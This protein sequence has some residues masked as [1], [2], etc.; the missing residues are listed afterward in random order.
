[1]VGFLAKSTAGHDKNQIYLIVGESGDSVLLADGR[2]R[3]CENPKKK[4]KK[5]IQVI[6]KFEDS[7]LT[8]TLKE[9]GR[10]DAGRIVHEVNKCLKQM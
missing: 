6:K 10:I 2:I 1:M 9:T 5:H 4:N 7:L 8:E 3:T